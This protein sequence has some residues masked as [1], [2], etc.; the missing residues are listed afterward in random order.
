[1]AIITHI[2]CFNMNFQLFFKETN[3]KSHLTAAEEQRVVLNFVNTYFF[4][5]MDSNLD[6]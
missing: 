6:N 1:M 3:G 2:P 4:L 5:F